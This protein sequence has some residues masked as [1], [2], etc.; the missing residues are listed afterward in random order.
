VKS[1]PGLLLSLAN[2][3]LLFSETYIVRYVFYYDDNLKESQYEITNAVFSFGV[4]V[5]G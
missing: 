2:N 1:I 3:Q 4:D 5:I